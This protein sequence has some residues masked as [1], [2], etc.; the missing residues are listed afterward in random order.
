MLKNRKI[1]V[2]VEVEAQ[3]KSHPEVAD[4]TRN[5]LATWRVTGTKQYEFA[6]LIGDLSTESD[7][8]PEKET[9]KKERFRIK[10]INER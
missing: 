4:A 1:E 10:Q 2:A 7:L 6:V 5:A 3:E 8:H 9:S